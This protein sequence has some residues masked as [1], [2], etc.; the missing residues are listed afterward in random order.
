MQQQDVLLV[1]HA[2]DL[3]A[4]LQQSGNRRR[5]RAVLQFGVAVQAGDA[6]QPGQVD[7]AIDPVHLAFAEV[8][9]LEQEVGQVLRAG[10]GHLQA[11]RIAVAP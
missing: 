2:E 5:E 9:L 8:E 1:D 7:R 10:V 6:E 11:H 4:V 3:V